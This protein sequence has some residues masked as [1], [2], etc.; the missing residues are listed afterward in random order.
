MSVADAL[1][2]HDSS[3]SSASCFNELLAA[4]SGS[5]DVDTTS[6]TTIL[7][8][9][10]DDADNNGNHG[11]KLVSPL[12]TAIAPPPRHRNVATGRFP[13]ALDVSQP[14]KSWWRYFGK[15]AASNTALCYACGAIFNRGPKQSTT[16]LS[17]HLKMYHR[18]EDQRR[19]YVAVFASNLPSF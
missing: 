3:S 17:H 1:A 15:Q 6:T 18:Y 19:K 4:I 16:S 13:R 11:N 9:D 2:A 8:D 12:P 5:I 7:A 14:A 10:A